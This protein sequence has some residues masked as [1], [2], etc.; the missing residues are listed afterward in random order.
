MNNDYL[1]LN[2]INKGT[3]NIDKG[4]C[5]ERSDLADCFGKVYCVVDKNNVCDNGSYTCTHFPDDNI[6]LNPKNKPVIESI[7]YDI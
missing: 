7:R 3:I 5:G 6:Y 4:I 1:E 2:C